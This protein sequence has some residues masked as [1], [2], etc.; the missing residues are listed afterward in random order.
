MCSCE[1]SQNS[2]IKLKLFEDF[3]NLKSVSSL[4]LTLLKVSNK[5]NLKKTE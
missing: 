4:L 1:Y 5:A 3:F 2:E